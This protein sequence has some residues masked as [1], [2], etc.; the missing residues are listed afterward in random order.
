MFNTKEAGEGP[1]QNTLYRE[2]YLPRFVSKFGKTSPGLRQLLLCIEGPLD[3]RD[4]H[5][6][7]ASLQLRLA[8]RVLRPLVRD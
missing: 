7:G 1:F 6:A 4:R 8:P 3:R 2:G 5:S